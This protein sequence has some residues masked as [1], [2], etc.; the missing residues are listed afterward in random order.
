MRSKV[1]PSH[2][3]IEIAQGKGHIVNAVERG[4]EFC[5]IDGALGDIGGPNIFGRTRSEQCSRRSSSAKFQEIVTGFE[6][7]VSR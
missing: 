1:R 4:V 3:L 2:R 7:S 6:G 5:E